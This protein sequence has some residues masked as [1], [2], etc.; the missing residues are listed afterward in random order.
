[1][2][3]MLLSLDTRVVWLDFFLNRLLFASE[4]G[5]VPSVALLGKVICYMSICV[6]MYMG[7]N[8]AAFWYGC[9]M[10]CT[11]YL[12]VWSFVRWWPQDSPLEGNC[13][14]YSHMR[15]LVIRLSYVGEHQFLHTH[16]VDQSALFLWRNYFPEGEP[17]SPYSV[18]LVDDDSEWN[19]HRPFCTRSTHSVQYYV[20]GS[21]RRP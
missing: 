20:K 3:L 2:I 13:Y 11:F 4:S 19:L 14:N 12:S 1:L 15:R 5:S 18:E 21:Q 8:T 9:I 6:C 16:V 7:P 17:Y 10:Y